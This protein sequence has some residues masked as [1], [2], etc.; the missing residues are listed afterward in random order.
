[1]R[2]LSRRRGG[3]EGKSKAGRGYDVKDAGINRGGEEGETVIEQLFKASTSFLPSSHKP[4]TP[5]E[6]MI[7]MTIIYSI[8]VPPFFPKFT[9]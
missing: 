3:R 7:K 4:I 6:T 8:S 9:F 1:M 5:A 2:V